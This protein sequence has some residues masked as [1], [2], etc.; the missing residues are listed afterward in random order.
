MKK[1]DYRFMEI[2]MIAAMMMNF[3]I[4]NWLGV[5]VDAVLLLF[6]RLGERK[7]TA[8]LTANELERMGGK[9]V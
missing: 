6:W 5:V 1:G 2:I 7:K 4:R 9:H 3:Y 8:P